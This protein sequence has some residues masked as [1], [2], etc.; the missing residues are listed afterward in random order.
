M[1]LTEVKELL[2]LAAP[3][4]TIAGAVVGIFKYFSY[5]SR[6]D[7]LDAVGTRFAAVVDGLGS[8]D[9][10]KRRAAAIMLRRFFDPDSEF[11]VDGTPYRTEAINVIAAVLRE[12]RSGS[13]QK[14]LADGLAYA[15]D[16]RGADLQKTNL[17]NAYL[18]TSISLGDYEN[19]QAEG[20]RP[21]VRPAP[22]RLKRAD[23]F[24]ADLS[25]ASLK[26]AQAQEAVFYQA[27][28]ART[29]FRDADLRGANFMEAD[30]QGARF[31]GA[32]LEGANF[33]GANLHGAAF[34][35]A[36]GIPPEVAEGLDQHGVWS[37]GALVSKQGR[38]RVF[39]SRPAQMREQGIGL[40]EQ[41]RLQVGRLG[42]IEFVELPRTDYPTFG[43]LTEVGKLV[44]TCH[45]MVVLG[46]GELQIADATWRLG[47]PDE[48]RVKDAQWPSP[49]SQIEAGM[50]IGLGLPVLLVA[51]PALDTGIFAPDADGHR[52]YRVAGVDDLTS[53]PPAQRLK[54]WYAAV[55]DQ[56]RA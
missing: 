47:T 16:L 17:Q 2:G 39:L 50:A 9:E 8:K 15:Q 43:A 51:P 55:A 30:L 40:L 44:N 14:L 41:V 12:E 28:L 37:G 54:D 42:P 27:R 22:L 7:R 20:P 32:N 25:G 18:V 36:T 4:G 46:L 56:A 3:L 10:V 45:G 21:E 52:I 34:A 35:K 53:G 26:G 13:F 33:S 6:K 1:T 31:T 23:F 19:D 48:R 5:R 24:R 49:W 11:G 29:V 38:L